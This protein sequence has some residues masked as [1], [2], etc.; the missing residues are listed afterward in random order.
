M[1]KYIYLMASLLSLALL[2]PSRAAASG[3]E[4][5]GC[6]LA[7]HPNSLFSPITGVRFD[8]EGRVELREGAVGKILQGDKVVAEGVLSVSNYTND[9]ESTGSVFID[10]EEPLVLPKGETFVAVLEKDAVQRIDNP[11]LTNDE[12][13]YPFTIPADLGNYRYASVEEG[14]TLEKAISIVFTWATETAD[15]NGTHQAVLYREG[16]AVRKYPIASS[17]DWGMG[18]VIVRFG[19]ELCFEKGVNY[20]L[21]LP[22]GTVA[23]YLR[24]DITNKEAV[25]NFVGGY[26]EP[27]PGLHYVWCNLPSCIVD[28]KL[29]E[30]VYHYDQAVLL[31]PYPVVQ[32]RLADNSQVVKEVTPTLAEEDGLWVLRA[33][34]GQTPLTSEKGYMVVIPEG[35][36]VTADGDIAVNPR[37]TVRLD[38]ATGLPSLSASVPAIA[39]AAGGIAVDGL[40]P[41]TPVSV[42]RA[43]GTLHFSTRAATS[44]LLVR[45]GKGAY[46]VALPGLTAKVL[47]E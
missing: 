17:W 25:L 37:N 39:P 31:S 20:S 18:T 26:T 45:A 32:L 41:G 8:F 14:G 43:D 34:F 38:G 13:R 46:V 3:L 44:S 30:V 29:G 12:V 5:K 47:V 24:P 23:A 15:D 36:L 16:V 2:F 27:L 40:A 19:G 22:E 4:Y 7:Y 33:D 11:E 28:G 6:S 35:T 42:Y 9:Q 21:V 1:K 10:F